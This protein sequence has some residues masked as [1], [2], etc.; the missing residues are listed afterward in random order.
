MRIPLYQ[1]DAFAGGRLTG[2]PAAVC[3]LESRCP[4]MSCRVLRGDWVT[5]ASRA[6]LYLEG[7][8]AI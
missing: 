1:I 8:I 7:I 3:P 4:A 6:T 2:N 5:I